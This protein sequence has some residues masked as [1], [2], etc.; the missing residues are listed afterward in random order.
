MRNISSSNT[1]AVERLNPANQTGCFPALGDENGIIVLRDKE[2]CTWK[3]YTSVTISLGKDTYE[4]YGIP[5]DHWIT[6]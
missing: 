5:V 2:E 6:I 4:S 1:R 3:W